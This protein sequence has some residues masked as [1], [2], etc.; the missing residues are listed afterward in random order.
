MGVIMRKMY[1]II[2]G[3]LFLQS[4]IAIDSS[5]K[6]T[7]V[8]NGGS[9]VDTILVNESQ[10]IQFKDSYREGYK[11]NGWYMSSD[12]GE[13][14][15][16]MWDFDKDIVTEDIT[17][18]AD[19]IT[20]EKYYLEFINLR[21][22][23]YSFEFTRIYIGEQIEETAKYQ[24]DYNL[25]INSRYGFFCDV[26]DYFTPDNL[27]LDYYD[28]KSG[29]TEKYYVFSFLRIIF[30]DFELIDGSYQYNV[31]NDKDGLINFLFPEGYLR[32][33]EIDVT[34]DEIDNLYDEALELGYSINIELFSEVESFEIIITI[35]ESG[36]TYKLNYTFY[37]Y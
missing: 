36:E 35:K 3:L 17:L 15:D 30:D 37:F 4:C 9:N 11:L 19:W 28:A 13:T 22:G 2:L 21:E 7:F 27:F 34:Q 33:E 18:Y 6:V 10:K 1:L 12:N 25:D 29:Y 8:T 14:I 32:Y 31:M 23:K 26:D 5:H 20:L 16:L 24:C